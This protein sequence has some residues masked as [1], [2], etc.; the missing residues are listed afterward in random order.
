MSS[1]F[2]EYERIAQEIYEAN[3]NK[4]YK[5][6]G[7]LSKCDRYEYD[8]K[9]ITDLVDHGGNGE[10]YISFYLYIPT[11]ETRVMEQVKIKTQSMLGV[12]I[13]INFST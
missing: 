5:M 8:I 3:A 9:P 12:I 7:C 6:T 11:G 1:Q 10:G 4:I 13:D 2:A